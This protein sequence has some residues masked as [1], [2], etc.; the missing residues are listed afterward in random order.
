MEDVIQTQNV[1]TQFIS[2]LDA[3][4]SE[5]V[6]ACMKEK[7]L[8]Y[9]SLTNPKISNPIDLAQESW[10]FGNQDSISAHPFELDQN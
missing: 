8:S 1:V 3:T 2:W 6:N 5:L 7:T 4:M 9:Q 10:W